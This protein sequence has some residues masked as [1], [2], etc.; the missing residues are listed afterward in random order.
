MFYDLATGA[1]HVEGVDIRTHLHDVETLNQFALKGKYDIT[2][3][4]FP[5]YLRVQDQYELLSA[6]AAVG[7]GCGPLVVAKREIAPADV[8]RCRVAVPGDLTTAYLLLRLWAPSVGEVVEARYDLIMGMVARGEV[9][10]GVL[11]HESRFVYQQMGLKCLVD[12]GQ[13]WQAST[14]LPIPLGC[15]IAR[16]SLGSDLIR[17]FEQT[18]RQGIIHSKAC[19]EATWPYVRKHAQEMD[20]DT[21][22]RHIQM[23]VNDFSI[24]M[25][26]L[27][28]A[29]VEKLRTLARKAGVIA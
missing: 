27:G 21:I 25:G 7:F 10:C 14:D 23:F 9:D 13:W 19:P 26:P 29:A 15:I 4:S 6:G 3:V 12:L 28:H 11:I 20:Q 8:A 24:D 5:A 16:K 22:M 2:K 18:L 1:S 17:R